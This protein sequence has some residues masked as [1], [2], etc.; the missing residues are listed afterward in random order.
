MGSS[1]FQIRE[2]TGAPVPSSAGTGQPGGAFALAQRLAEH[3][4][5]GVIHKS[6]HDKQTTYVMTIV[7]LV[8]VSSTWTK[9]R[10]GAPAALG[11]P[12]SREA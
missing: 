12:Y 7:T 1:T 11:E 2:T 5:E 10:F 9:N 6:E 4:V 3:M 8:L